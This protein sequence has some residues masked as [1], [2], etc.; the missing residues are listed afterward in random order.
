M[1]SALGQATNCVHDRS[2]SGHHVDPLLSTY[3]L[4]RLPGTEGAV[5][6][7][8]GANA[9]FALGELLLN[10]IPYTPYLVGYMGL[11]TSIYG[12]WAFT[13][14]RLTGEWIYVVRLPLLCCV[15]DIISE[16]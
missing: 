12:L 8:H 16:R 1:W 6:L 2:K 11:Y 10:R 4:E 14:F 5:F 3:A 7:Q 9:A 15:C 13:Y